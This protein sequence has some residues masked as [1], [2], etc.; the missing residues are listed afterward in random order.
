MGTYLPGITKHGI[1]PRWSSPGHVTIL[2]RGRLR[3]GLLGWACQAG[4]WADSLNPLSL[5]YLI[6]QG[7][8]NTYLVELLY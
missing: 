3:D 5:L 7:D 2:G 6:C 1:Q 4:P 8:S